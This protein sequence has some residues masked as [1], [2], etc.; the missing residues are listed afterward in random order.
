MFRFK[1]VL[2]RFVLAPPIEGARGE[3]PDRDKDDLSD[4]LHDELDEVEI[5]LAIQNE[6]HNLIDNPTFLVM[7][8]QSIAKLMNYL[9]KESHFKSHRDIEGV[10]EYCGYPVLSV[11]PLDGQSIIMFI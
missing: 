9:R 4:F 8:E 2:K 1:S 3:P 5:L 6:W 10:I 11:G 7:D